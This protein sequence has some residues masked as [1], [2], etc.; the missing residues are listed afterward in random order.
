LTFDSWYTY[1]TG[2]APYY[3]YVMKDAQDHILYVGI[4]N[5]LRTRMRAHYDEKPWIQEVVHISVVPCGSEQYA[6]EKEEELIGELGP[7]YNIVHNA[8]GM[9]VISYLQDKYEKAGCG[10]VMG[11]IQALEWEI[12]SL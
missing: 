9:N 2:R 7:V 3:V 4:T 1:T 12:T 10:G 11:S 6:R 5:S 8:H